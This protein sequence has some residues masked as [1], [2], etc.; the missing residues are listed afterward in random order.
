MCKLKVELTQI[1]MSLQKALKDNPQLIL[2]CATAVNLLEPVIRN[3]I[4]LAIK[5]V[6]YLFK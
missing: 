2:Q 4:K 3:I 5:A 1:N 6:H